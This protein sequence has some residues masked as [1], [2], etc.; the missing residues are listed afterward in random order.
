[1]AIAAKWKVQG[2]DADAGG[3]AVSSE[4]RVCANCGHKN[5]RHHAFCRSCGVRLEAEGVGLA[6]E[7]GGVSGERRKAEAPSGVSGERSKAAGGGI[8][9]WL[10][11]LGVL[12]IVAPF[13]TLALLLTVRIVDEGEVG[14]VYM[15]GEVDPERDRPA[16]ISNFRGRA[17]RR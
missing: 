17:W 15:F 5:R 9:P 4:D 7:T 10:V 12:L 3:G 1:M 2:V 8:R 6:E 11:G 16:C 13:L 14:V